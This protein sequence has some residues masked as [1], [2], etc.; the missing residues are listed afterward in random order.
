MNMPCVEVNEQTFLSFRNKNDAYYIEAVSKTLVYF[1]IIIIDS[2][3]QSTMR[4]PRLDFSVDGRFFGLKKVRWWRS[5][6]IFRTIHKRVEQLDP[7]MSISMNRKRLG[8]NSK[9]GW[10]AKIRNMVFELP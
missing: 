4:V 8:K 9:T 7:K 3:E 6:G 5:W 1:I 2:C 10:G